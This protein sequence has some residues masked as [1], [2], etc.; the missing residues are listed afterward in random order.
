MNA[1]DTNRININSPYKV[2]AEG[3]VLHFETENGIRYAVDFDCE[4]NPLYTAYWLNLTNESHKPSPSDRLIP[5]T[6]ICIVEEFSDR[7]RTSCYTCVAQT[8]TSKHNGHVCSCD[9]LMAMSSS[10]NLSSGLP[11]C[12]VLIPTESP[13]RN[14]WQSSYRD[15]TLKYK[16]LLTSSTRKSP[17]SAQTS[18]KTKSVKLDIRRR[19]RLCLDIGRWRAGW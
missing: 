17:C 10:R 3:Q 13:S 18:H 4:D 9:G 8:I 7:T 2:W 1:L 19:V 5:K 15:L 12:R 11:K 6:L 14:M 16:P